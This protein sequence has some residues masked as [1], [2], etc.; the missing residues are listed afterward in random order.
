MEKKIE[1]L[2]KDLK[3]QKTSLQM[4]VIFPNGK[5]LIKYQINIRCKNTLNFKKRR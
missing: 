4:E 2:E 3:M 1:E 5:V